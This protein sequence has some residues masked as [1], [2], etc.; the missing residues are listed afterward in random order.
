MVYGGQNVSEDII[1]EVI[2]LNLDSKK[3]RWRSFKAPARVNH[4][5]IYIPNLSGGNKEY[6]YSFG[7][8][9]YRSDTM[10]EEI[11]ND[12]VLFPISFEDNHLALRESSVCQT[13][14]LPRD[15]CIFCRFDEGILIMGGCSDRK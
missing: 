15:S 12:I 2:V 3:P 11:S 10:E 6:L 7:G 1:G 4:Q 5:L 13:N 14:F 9:K 8:L